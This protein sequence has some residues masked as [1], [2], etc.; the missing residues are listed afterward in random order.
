[1]TVYG[2]GS[3]TRSFCFIDDM[4]DGIVRLLG[5]TESRPVNLGNPREVS[6]QELAE[7]INDL[8]GN[9]AGFVHRPLPED[10][11]KVRQ[12]DVSRAREVLGWEA[13]VT[14]EDGIARTAEWFRASMEG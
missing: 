14:L 2:D 7:M 8:T 9:E 6:I 11:P 1:M 10:D 3:Q 4:V 5:A 13:R 12:P